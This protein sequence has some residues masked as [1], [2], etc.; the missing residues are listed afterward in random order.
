MKDEWREG[1]FNLTFKAKLRR[2]SNIALEA[3]CYR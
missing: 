1:F 3:E 2:L